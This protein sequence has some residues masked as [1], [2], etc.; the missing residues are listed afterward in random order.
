MDSRYRKTGKFGWLARW[1][2]FKFKHNDNNSSKTNKNPPST[3]YHRLAASK[4]KSDKITTRSISP[5]P[6][7]VPAE[8]ENTVALSLPRESVLQI[9][10]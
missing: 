7:K 3:S 4:R 6:F 9:V 8:R 1:P 10:R 5:W 2:V